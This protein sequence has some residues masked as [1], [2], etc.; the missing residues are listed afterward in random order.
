MV[1]QRLFQ[2][3]AILTDEPGYYVDGEVGFRIESEVVECD[4]SLGKTRQGENFLGFNYL[5]K[6]PF[7]E[8]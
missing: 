4:G 3:G 8:N 1:H 6:V 5:T 7:A 2:P